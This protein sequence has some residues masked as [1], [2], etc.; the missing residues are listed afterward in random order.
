MAVTKCIID[1]DGKQISVDVTMSEDHSFEADVSSYPVESGGDITDNVRIKP[2][3]VKWECIISDTP[4]DVDGGQTTI[5]GALPQIDAYDA[6]TAL[7]KARQTIIIQDSLDVFDSMMI[8]AVSIPRSAQNGSALVFSI[9]FQQVLILE[10]KRDTV[11]VHLGGQGGKYKLGKYLSCF[12]VLASRRASFN[13]YHLLLTD[14][15]DMFGNKTNQK[16]DHYLVDSSLTG[17]DTVNGGPLSTTVQQVNQVN[18]GVTNFAADGWV[19]EPGNTAYHSSYRVLADPLN[20]L[21]D[22]T[23]IKFDDAQ[24][25]YVGDDGKKLV[26]NPAPKA[27]SGKQARAFWNN[28]VGNT[29]TG[30]MPGT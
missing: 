10:N 8:T 24:G 12:T 19:D 3:S 27:A 1:T 28:T 17:I 4:I 20:P 22:I 26:Q 6:I 23:G 11:V 18:V 15:Q 7:F 29:G 13:G 2:L 30:S 21:S 25:G 14:N 5:F 16:W 9:T